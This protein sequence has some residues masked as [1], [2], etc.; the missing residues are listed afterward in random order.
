MSAREQAIDASYMSERTLYGA[1]EKITHTMGTRI[2]Q[3][4]DT[5]WKEGNLARKG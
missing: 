3:S 5:V 2:K 4:N 1:N